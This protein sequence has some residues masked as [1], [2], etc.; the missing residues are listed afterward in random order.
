MASRS[1]NTF[2]VCGL[3]FRYLLNHDIWFLE[4]VGIILQT[5]DLLSVILYHYLERN[6][7]EW[8]GT[9]RIGTEKQ[10]FQLC[11]NLNDQIFTQ[12]VFV[13]MIVNDKNEVKA[14]RLLPRDIGLEALFFL[15]CKSIDLFSESLSHNLEWNGTELKI[16]LLNFVG[17][18]MSKFLLNLFWFR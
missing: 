8:N 11:W 16:R 10:T 3:G 13:Q 12:S 17:T 4:I 14:C 15:P 1:I 18:L 7:T 5:I 6:G 9:E 2:Y